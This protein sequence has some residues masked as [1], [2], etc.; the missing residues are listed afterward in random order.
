[1]KNTFLI[2]CL[3]TTIF[4]YS[5]K[6]IS[7]SY[8]MDLKVAY[9]PD[10]KKITGY[11]ESYTG[12]DGGTPMFSC[13]FY[14]EG[15]LLTDTAKVITFYPEEKVKDTISGYIYIQ[16]NKNI[17]IKLNDDHGGCWNVQHFKDEPVEF[18]LLEKQ[19]YIQI[20][21]ADKDKV[22]FYDTPSE[23]KRRRAYVIKGNI[24]YVEKLENGWALCTYFGRKPVTGWIK[25][26]DLNQL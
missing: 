7:G 19:D 21:F 6:L 16:D 1:M 23:A 4:C 10:S 20:R 11:F 5:Q 14:L 22:Y 13:I 9:N 8:D 17:T 12:D 2:I 25:T 18:S 24:L 3:I 26:S 15:T